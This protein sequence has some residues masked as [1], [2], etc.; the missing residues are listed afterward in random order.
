M[1]CDVDINECLLEEKCL[2]GTCK[3]LPGSYSCECQV[4]YVGSSCNMVD[5]CVPDSKN[6]TLHNCVHGNCINPRVVK[7]PSGRDVVEYDCSCWE[8]YT[9]QFCSH[10]VSL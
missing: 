1:L 6:R 3:N 2:N 7:Q 10:V 5:P 8:H 4:G 9:G